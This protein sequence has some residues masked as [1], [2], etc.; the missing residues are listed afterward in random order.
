MPWFFPENL[1]FSK[2]QNRSLPRC[3][4]ST[5]ELAAEEWIEDAENWELS[6]FCLDFL[7]STRL[8]VFHHDQATV[9]VLCQA[10]TREFDSL[11]M[12]FK[13]I[14]L[15]LRGHKIAARSVQGRQKAK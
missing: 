13:A 7:V 9:A 3:R 14:T 10:E 5:L 8:S 4:K 15:S 11:A 1:A 12:V 6:F 2:L